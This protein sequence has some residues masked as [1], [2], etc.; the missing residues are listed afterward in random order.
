LSDKTESHVGLEA[1][2]AGASH[3]WP[4][5]ETEA[6]RCTRAAEAKNNPRTRMAIV[7]EVGTHRLAD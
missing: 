5:D 3:L 1:Q 7:V 6:S 2:G 4:G